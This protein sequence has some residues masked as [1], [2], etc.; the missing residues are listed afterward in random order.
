MTATMLIIGAAMKILMKT[1]FCRRTKWSTLNEL[2]GIECCKI[3]GNQWR[4]GRPH[5]K[6]FCAR[7]F[8]YH[9]LANNMDCSSKL[10]KR[11]VK[12]DCFALAIFY[13]GCTSPPIRLQNDNV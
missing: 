3:N 11:R 10:R 6:K 12:C 13:G 7:N 4:R 5:R 2:I 8:S 9:P 1:K